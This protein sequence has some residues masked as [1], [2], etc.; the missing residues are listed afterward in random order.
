[1]KPADGRPESVAVWAR[2]HAKYQLRI[3]YIMSNT[4]GAG[5]ASLRALGDDEP[6]GQQPRPK[7]LQRE[8]QDPKIGGHLFQRVTVL[9]AQ[10][11]DPLVQTER[12]RMTP[13]LPDPGGR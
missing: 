4:G 9:E 2:R 11:I 5:L 3:M 1:M 10:A 13:G 6:R 7:A 12:Q 8:H